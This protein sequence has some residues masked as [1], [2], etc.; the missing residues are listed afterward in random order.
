MLFPA[1]TFCGSLSHR[2]KKLDNY[3]Q[4]EKREIENCAEF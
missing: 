1:I 3:T 4:E 2:N